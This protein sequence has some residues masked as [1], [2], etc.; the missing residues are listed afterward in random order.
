M[1]NLVSIVV[2]VYNVEK[3][4]ER[5]IQSILNQT[6]NNLEIIMVNDGSTDNSLH[7]LTHYQDQD[8]RIKIIDQK[9]QGLS[10]A[11]NSG[12]K[13][14]KGDYILF[15]DSDDIIES[16]LIADC[17]ELI[18][19]DKSDIIVYGYKKVKEDMTLIAEPNFGNTTLSKDEAFKK[20][21]RL[22]ISPM[23]CNKFIKTDLLKKYNIE[24]PLSKL[25]EDIGTTYKIFWRASQVSTTSKSYYYWINREESITSSIT[26]KHINHLIELLIEKKIFLNNLDI[27]ENY[28]TSYN[29]GVLKLLNLMLERSLN[30]Y[31]SILEYVLHII[32]DELLISK[33][34]IELIKSE[35]LQHFN[36]F[37]KLYNEAKKDI[38]NN[39]QINQKE[40]AKLKTENRHLT[41]E[42]EQIK[43]SVFYKISK[44]YYIVRD[45]LL[46]IGSKR[47]KILKTLIKG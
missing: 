2:P 28:K 26:F 35:E 14:A 6:Y 25:H 20:L 5:C 41:E 22:D 30:A 17:L 19:K 39:K 31:S 43:N 8:K 42:L 21:L 38:N 13:Y 9:N 23:A 37:Q 11:R 46:P 34:D 18:Q 44:K 12:I 40:L 29:V 32:D 3:L 15:V 27:F 7:I 4:V 24:F 45:F 47:R 1:N 33:E 10:G 16:S 36:K